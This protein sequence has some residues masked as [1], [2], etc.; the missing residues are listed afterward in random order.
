MA[1][2]GDIDFGLLIEFLAGTSLVIASACVFNN[3]IDRKIDARMAR[4]RNRA[5]ANGSISVPIAS[6]YA[7]VLG[8][9]GFAILLFFTPLFSVWIGFAAYI[10]YIL[11]YGW[12]KRHTVHGTVIGS[13]AGSLPPVAAYF[14]VA[15]GL[16]TGAWLVFLIYTAW[17]MPHFYAIAMYRYDDYKAAGLPVLPVVKGFQQTKIQIVAYIAAFIVATSLLT[18]F[19][20]TGYIYLFVMLIGG[21]WWLNLAIKGFKTDDDVKWAKSVFGSSL[22]IISLLAVMMSVG[23]ILP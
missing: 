2:R 16:D 11:L 4:T 17:Q 21:L 5:T 15:G 20:Y 3:V 14:A 6:A 12:A 19:G 9:A 23:S 8:I 18:V 1:S 13:I 10:V 22:L 7:T